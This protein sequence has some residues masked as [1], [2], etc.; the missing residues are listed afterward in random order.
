MVPSISNPPKKI[1]LWVLVSKLFIAAVY[2]TS[3][4]VLTV[5]AVASRCLSEVWSMEYVSSVSA[6]L[7]PSNKYRG[8]GFSI[9]AGKGLRVETERA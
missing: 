3:Q 4:T 7:Y 2:G 8:E 5:A 1:F 6:G 9:D